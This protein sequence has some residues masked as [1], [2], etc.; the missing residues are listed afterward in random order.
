MKTFPCLTGPAVRAARALRA[1]WLLALLA[2]AGVLLMPPQPVQ[3]Q[4]ATGTIL[5]NVKDNTG[6]AVPGATITATNVNT[7]ATRSTSTDDNGQYTLPLLPVGT[8]QVQVELAGFKNFVQNGILL[9]VGRNA[10]VDATI[11]PGSVQEVVSVNADAPLVE[12]NSASLT[13]TQILC[14]GRRC[15]RP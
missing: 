4:T 6:G 7:Q 13:R 10:R 11:E 9:E 8:Y 12:T 5:G 2:G 3:A 1:S 15:P 14:V